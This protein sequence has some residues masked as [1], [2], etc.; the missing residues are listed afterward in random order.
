[1]GEGRSAESVSVKPF[2]LLSFSSPNRQGELLNIVAVGEVFIISAFI[3][4]YA[5]SFG[6]FF[7]FFIGYAITLFADNEEAN[8]HKQGN[9]KA[10]RKEQNC[11]VGAERF[12]NLV[13]ADIVESDKNDA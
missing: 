4:A 10:Q 2:A 12:K 6:N 1:M 7:G 5:H 13:K 8:R 11:I 3:P 9:C